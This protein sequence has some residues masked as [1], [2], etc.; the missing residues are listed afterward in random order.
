MSVLTIL[1]ACSVPII[2]WRSSEMSLLPDTLQ[3][4]GGYTERHGRLM[5]PGGD[6]LKVRVRVL[7][8]GARQIVFAN[9]E[10]LTVPESLVREV[11]AALPPHTLLFMGATHTHCAPDSQRL[12]D[13]MTFDVPGI[14][15]YQRSQLDWVAG[16]IGEAIKRALAAKPSVITRCTWTQAVR[17]ANRGRRRLAQPQR[18]SQAM[19]F[20]SGASKVGEIFVYPAHATI[21]EASENH[22]RGDWPGA[23]MAQTGWLV[24]PGAIGDVSPKAD[25]P[26][27]TERIS[28]MVHALTG[29]S[30]NAVSGESGPSFEWAEQEISLGTP[31]PH[32]T[33]A[34]AY[35]VPPALATMAVKSFAPPTATIIGVRWGTTAW[36]GV[37]GEPTADLGR[38]I[39]RAGRNLGFS[40]VSVMSHVN[41]WAG[42]MLAPDD[43]DRGGYEA[44]LSFY[45][46]DSGQ[47]VVDAATDCLRQLANRRPGRPSTA[48]PDDDRSPA[49]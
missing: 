36:I 24:F 14:A 5:D 26:N 49:R 1:A 17:D 48:K 13:R 39:E 20:W 46:R 47:R 8:D 11:R 45:G 33:F 37:P 43:Y 19:E 2:T 25:G 28:K 42:Y 15:R 35:K 16:R 22:T 32:P 4:L 34:Q 41:G 10:Q 40:M 23:L 44:T 30:S 18:T 7:S 21:Y 27:S 3:P 29:R 38:A 6:D 12:N 31:K 9:L